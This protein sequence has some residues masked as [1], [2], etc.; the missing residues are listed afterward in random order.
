MVQHIHDERLT[1]QPEELF[2]VTRNRQSSAQAA[3]QGS[4]VEE[5][6]SASLIGTA[7]SLAYSEYI[8]RAVVANAPLILFALDP[9]GT[10]TLAAGRGFQSLGVRPEEL[11]G[12]SILS[13]H[14]NIPQIVEHICRAL[15]G[16]TITTVEQVGTRFFETCYM[17]QYQLTGEIAGV[18]GVGTDISKRIRIAEALEASERKF[19]SLTEQ[20][21][22][23]VFSI[24]AEGVYQYISPSHQRILGYAA[25]DLLGRNVFEVIHP[26]DKKKVHIAWQSAFEGSGALGVTECRIRHVDGSY[27]MVEAIGRNCLEDPEIRGFVVNARDITERMEMEQKLRYQAL[28]DAVTDLPNR[29]WLVERLEQAIHDATE[30]E[31]ALLILNLNRFKD[32]NDTFGHQKG[33]IL[34]QQV[35]HRLTQSLPPTCTVARL[36]GDEFAL[37]FPQVKGQTARQ[38]VALLHTLFEEPF[39][40]EEH[41]IQVDASIGGVLYP[42]HGADSPTLL[43]RANIAMTVA[44]QERWK[45]A[46]FDASY[47]QSTSERLDLIRDLRHAISAQQFM[48]YY[49]PK[50]DLKT[51]VVHS[52]EALIRWQH[53]TRGFVPPDTF[54]PLAEQTG[55]IAPL[56]CWVLKTALQQCEAWL[57]SGIDLEVAVNLSMWD[58]HDPSLM[59]TICT[60]LEQ[61]HVP[62]NYLRIE[63]TET[64]AMAD[65]NHTL[66]V[67]KH[68]ARIGVRC[69][70]DDF[71]TGYSSL[72]YLKRLLVNELKI[73]RSFV[74]HITEV[75]ADAT[76]VKSTVTMAHSLGLQVVA[77]GVEDAAAMRLLHDLGCDIAQGYYLSRPIPPQELSRWLRERA[78]P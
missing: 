50:V 10:F 5:K 56:T 1:T 73:D 68:L 26:A 14:E 65:A 72:S 58:L 67:L 76:I 16:E 37:L 77:E 27:I 57:R 6:A 30:H 25:E 47:E 35:A 42:L 18:I 63:L 53:P 70:I 39:I 23:L 2:S 32:I 78:D 11:V 60:L 55:L 43:R 7:R 66:E 12:T 40:V 15:D 69:S 24:S 46:L 28:H 74:Q 20:G 44:K 36:S 9:T 61:Y 29:A 54:I 3:V 75:E 22:D 13:M 8:L 31:M 17:P 52:V 49:Q 34:L 4:G 62:S 71:G 21:H 51:G 45:F 41:P 48:L 38:T 64:S 59:N 33:D 19:R